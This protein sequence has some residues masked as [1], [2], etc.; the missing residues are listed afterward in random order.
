MYVELLQV[1]KELKKL[2]LFYNNYY[3]RRDIYVF[4]VIETQVQLFYKGFLKIVKSLD[5]WKVTLNKHKWVND[6]C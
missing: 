6:I 1:V 4:T 2:N 5:N 3:L